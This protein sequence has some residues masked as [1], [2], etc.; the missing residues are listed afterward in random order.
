GLARSDTSPWWVADN[1]PDPD[2]SKSTL[3]T[4]GG[5]KVPLTVDVHGAPTGTVFAGVDGNF[6]IGTDSDSTPGPARF[7]F[8]TEDEGI[9]AWRGGTTALAAPTTGIAAGAIF[10][11]LAIA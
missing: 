6:L 8:A 10:N 2:H 1:G 7:I 11:G 3:Y 9:R 4:G 5:A